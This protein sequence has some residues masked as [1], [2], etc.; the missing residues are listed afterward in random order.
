MLT[1][2]DY[3][4]LSAYIDGALTEAERAAFELRLQS[5]TE[6]S[7][8]LDEL[9]ATVT[10]LNNLPPFKA[11]RDFTLDAR[12]TRR[13]SFF[14]TS[15]TFSALS[16]AAAII[17]FAFGAYLFTGKNAP[18]NTSSASAQ[19]GQAG[20]VQQ[21]QSTQFAFVPTATNA[22]LDKSAAATDTS[23]ADMLLLEV[24]LTVQNSPVIVGDEPTTAT[25]AQENIIVQPTIAAQS[26]L[27]QPD[28]IQ[29]PASPD[30]GVAVGSVVVAPTS[31]EAQGRTSEATET[32]TLQQYAAPAASA[33]TA[34]DS[35]GSLAV[36]PSLTE[37]SANDGAP[38]VPMTFETP[39]GGGAAVPPSPVEETE[40]NANT[41]LAAQPTQ[42]PM[43]ATAAPQATLVPTATPSPEPTAT[44]VPT[45]THTSQPTVVPTLVPTLQDQRDRFGSSSV[46]D[47]LPLLL[48]GLGIALLFIAIGTT[49]IRRRNRP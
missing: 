38:A 1:D 49:I 2:L 34:N 17:L 44:L 9:R 25:F 13:S 24:T 6:L 7:R 36:P 19:Q 29:P 5:E 48:I 41:G 39:S 3:E 15:A 30:D 40:A 47:S 33:N 10:L 11:P 16:T 20:Q 46:P 26:P 14:F 42:L 32:T 45:A 28:A 4:L 31:L 37:A 27:F 21:D 35:T 22:T 23:E 8:E 43:T 12:Y 18:L